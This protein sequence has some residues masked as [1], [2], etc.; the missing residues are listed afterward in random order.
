MRVFLI[1]FLALSCSLPPPELRGRVVKVIDG[2]TLE[3][4]EG[5]TKTRVR[6]Y[7]ID[8]PERGQD[9]SN[10]SKEFLASLVAGHDVRVIQIRKD[11]WQR[12]VG[13]VFLPDGSY[14]NARMV[15]EGWAWHF[16]LYS[17]DAT[18]ARLEKQARRQ[19]RGLW[20]QEM[21]VPPWEYRKKKRSHKN[22]WQSFRL[23][24]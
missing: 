14:V 15:E 23:M 19:R 13:E 4:L 12:V 18:L 2:D 22:G 24:R 10:R 17:D 16:T 20:R 1:A 3:V 8:A 11:R 21:P 9:F 6:L 7:G 5:N